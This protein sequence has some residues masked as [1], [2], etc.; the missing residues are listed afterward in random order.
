MNEISDYYLELIREINAFF[1]HM[2]I[3]RK[4]TSWIFSLI[5]E[6]QINGTL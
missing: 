3:Y 6:E 2:H 5:W 1:L 4:M